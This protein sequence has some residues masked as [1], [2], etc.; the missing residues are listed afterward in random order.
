M[1]HLLVLAS[2]FA[3]A[4]I[5]A[6]QQQFVLMTDLSNDK[7]VKFDAFDGALLDANFIPDAGSATTYNFDIPR[8]V[9]QVGA[10][11]WVLD[12]S[13]PIV[14]FNHIG[15]WLGT[16]PQSVS[17]IA[18]ARGAAYVNGVVYVANDS[19]LFG[20]PVDSVVML[21][22]TGAPIGSFSVADSGTSPIDVV[23]FNGELLVSHYTYSHSIGR[24][25][26]AGT[27]LPPPFMTSIIG[28]TLHLPQQIAATGGGTLLATGYTQPDGVFEYD[29]TGAQIN[30]WWTPNPARGVC[31]LGDGNIL[32]ATTANVRKIDRS[33]GTTSIVY[34]FSGC[35]FGKITFTPP[36]MEVYCTAGVSTGGCTPAISASRQPSASFAQACDI[37]VS[38]VEPQRPGLVFYGVNGPSS[39]SWG[40][41]STSLLCVNPPRQRTIAHS[42]G[43]SPGQCDGQ[44]TLDWNAY[45]LANPSSI[46]SPWAAG[47]RIWLQGWYR[48]PQ[49]PKGTNLSDALELM[50]L[51]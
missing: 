13:G 49:A 24:Y 9:F 5:S 28:P 39:F 34:G 25:D 4:G 10:E 42:S 51:P 19:G 43:G 40:F 26:Y 37:T 12:H 23:E 17:T 16:V 21:D 38:G 36:P 27:A 32:V 50:C 44:L 31:E 45:Q 35:Y 7:V 15:V 47:D 30:Y 6:A 33:T 48:D 29:M 14:R 1:N 22:T 20:A 46:G 41:G 18:D 11:I 2:W 8:E 3:L